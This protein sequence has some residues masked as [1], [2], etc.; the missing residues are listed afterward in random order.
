MIF[1][2][3]TIPVMLLALVVATV[4]VLKVMVRDE[5][6]RRLAHGASA[7]VTELVLSDRAE[8][9][10]GFEDAVAA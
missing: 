10:S 6:Q 2:L 7:E 3:I 4:P 1:A 5:R 8:R 9:T